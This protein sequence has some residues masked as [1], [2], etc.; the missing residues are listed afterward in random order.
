VQ[1]VIFFRGLT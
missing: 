1:Y